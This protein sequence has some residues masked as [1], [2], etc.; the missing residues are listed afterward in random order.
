MKNQYELPCNI[1]QTLNIIG[2]KWT[3]LIVHEIMLGDKSYNELL[4]KLTGI[5]SNLLSSRLKSLE[6][7]GIIKGELYQAHPP[8]Y[9]Y[10]LTDK[11]RDLEDVFNSII[12][13]G[14]RHL[15]KCYKKLVDKKS[16]HKVEIRY[17]LPETKE[18][19]NKEDVEAREIC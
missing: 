5:A 1:A 7:D 9:K 13:W 15:N 16:G 14:S 8:R 18:L 3:L 19:L 17:Y 11:G 12:L 6:E 2:D 4:S 10:T